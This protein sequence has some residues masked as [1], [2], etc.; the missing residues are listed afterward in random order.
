KPTGKLVYC[1]L[2]GKPTG[3]L[4]YC[5]L[6]VKPTG[7]LVYCG[8]QGFITELSSIRSKN[9]LGHPFCGNLRDG[10][11]MME[12]ISGRLLVHES[13]REVGE[14]FKYQF[15]LLKQFPRY[16]IPAYFD[17][18]VTAAY[19]LCLDQSWSLMSQF[20]REGSSFIRALAFGS[21]QMVSKIPSSPL[22][23]LSPNL[24]ITGMTIGISLAAGL[25]HFA[26]EWFR[27]WGRDTFISL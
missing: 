1:G 7:K 21:I 27:N 22:P 3:K 16:L 15:D 11:W 2:Q 6:Q 5:G 17:A 26:K 14:W 19:T 24:D 9:D 4:V 18:I 10:N 23:D 8:L 25:P 13:T 12:Y 20:V